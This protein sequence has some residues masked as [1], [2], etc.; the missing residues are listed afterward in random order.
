MSL[1]GVAGPAE[2]QMHEGARP[3]PAGPCSCRKNN[4][5]FF[6]FFFFN[7]PQVL[8]LFAKYQVV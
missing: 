1:G 3:K 4:C 8:R 7:A 6:F 5:F 2:P